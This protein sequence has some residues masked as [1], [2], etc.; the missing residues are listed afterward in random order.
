[1][2][3]AVIGAGAVGTLLGG[4]LGK[5]EQVTMVARN[6]QL[7]GLRDGIRIEGLEDGR[8]GVKAVSST[9]SLPIQDAV[10][11]C[12]KAH[13]TVQALQ[14]SRRLIGPGTLLLVVQNGL[15]V[16][17]VADRVGFAR[18]NIGVAAMGVTYLGPGHV[19][20]AGKGSI[21]V[22]NI[23][24][25]KG[26]AMR[27][28]Q[29]LR[30]A[31]MD[32]KVSED[33]LRD[34]WAKAAINAAVNPI[35]AIMG[36]PNGCILESEEL[37]LLSRRLFIEAVAVG[38]WWK[39]IGPDDVTFDDVKRVLKATTSNRSS[40]LQDMDRGRRTEIDAIN[41]A[42]CRLAPMEEMVVA[43]R[44]VHALIKGMEGKG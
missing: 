23:A 6:G 30:S 44:A 14:D 2:K 13:D 20:Y 15:D 9:S 33:I 41:G 38:K 37:T 5:K 12:V 35:T 19:R 4:L 10:L 8:T 3:V 24:G 22:G 17:S 21:S 16:L 1:M 18:M 34:V 43:N 39:A 26:T 7:E 28:V 25:K 31:G 36:R 42:I 40:M 27:A 11:I 32:S 29:L